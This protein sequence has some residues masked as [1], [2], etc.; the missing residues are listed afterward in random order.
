[1][2]SNTSD[3]KQEVKSQTFKD[4]VLDAVVWDVANTLIKNITASTIEW[5]NSGFDGSPSFVTDPEGFFTDVGDQIAGSWIEGLGPIGRILCSPFDLQIRLAL[6]FGY[7]GRGDYYFTVGCR[8]SDV[9]KNIYNA[10]TGGQWGADGWQNWISISQ[11]QNNAFGV[12]IRAENDMLMRAAE[13]VGIQKTEL[14][15]GNGFRSFKKCKPNPYEPEEQICENTT[16]G[17][18]IETQLNSVIGSGQRKLEVADEINE[19]A[20]AL[21]NQLMNKIFSSSGLIGTSRSGSSYNSGKSYLSGLMSTYE[22]QVAQRD[23]LPP[24]GMSCGQTYR[25]VELLNNADGKSQFR[26]EKYDKMGWFKRTNGKFDV[27]ADGNKICTL[28]KP[29]TSLNPPAECPYYTIVPKTADSPIGDGGIVTGI[30]ISEFE[31]QFNLGC[32]NLATNSPTQD[33]ANSA[34]GEPGWGLEKP[35]TVTSQAKNVLIDEAGKVR[36]TQSSVLKPSYST[37]DRAIDGQYNTCF[38]RQDCRWKDDDGD[39]KAPLNYAITLNVFPSY[40]QATFPRSRLLKVKIY[41]MDDSS[42]G[43]KSIIESNVGNVVLKFYSNN[44]LIKEIPKTL[45][46]QNLVNPNVTRDGYSYYLIDISSENIVADTFKIELI[47]DG[48][49]HAYKNMLILDEVELLADTITINVPT[50]TSCDKLP[51]GREKYHISCYY[52][53]LVWDGKKLT[54]N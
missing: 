2:Q 19:I 6:G 21:L 8:L 52:N 38:L 31:S 36:V 40:W 29:G 26:V 32:S 10:F 3:I 46:A 16:P 49:G 25:Y 28:T 45:L 27:D 1:V 51:D 37:A 48:S 42:R 15:W 39:Y 53:E 41:P 11:P 50:F 54:V 17:A 22:S 18:V 44:N 14:S 33:L 7:M 4:C 23:V 30:E 9:Q 35:E 5:I 13:K 47:K 43:N 34:A 12:Y 20:D 24:K